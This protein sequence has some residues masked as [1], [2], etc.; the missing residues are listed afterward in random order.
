MGFESF[1]LVLVDSGAEAHAGKN[2]TVTT[3]HRCRID[4]PRDRV[5]LLLTKTTLQ[6]EISNLL[7][8]SKDVHFCL[9]N[10][11]VSLRFDSNVYLI[12]YLMLT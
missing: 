5:A 12:D 10:G 3:S 6:M 4:V 1:A 7:L 8:A 2:S 9:L 11:F